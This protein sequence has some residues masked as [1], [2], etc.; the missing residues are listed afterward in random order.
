MRGLAKALAR[1]DRGSQL[2]LDAARKLDLAFDEFLPDVSSWSKAGEYW[3]AWAYA[4]MLNGISTSAVNIISS[5]GYI[6]AAPALN[7]MAPSE[8]TFAIR[9]AINAQ[10]GGKAKLDAFARSSPVAAAAVKYVA[11]FK[12]IKQARRRASDIFYEGHIDHKFLEQGKQALGRQ[13]NIL[14][15]RAATF[16]AAKGLLGKYSAL[17]KFSARNLAAQDVFI[18]TIAHEMQLADAV[19]RADVFMKRGDMA[20]LG[21]NKDQ[22]E[23]AGYNLPALRSFSYPQWVNFQMSM[24][25]PAY[26]GA[27]EI[28]IQDVQAHEQLTGGLTNAQ[29]KRYVETRTKEVI[30]FG[31]TNEVTGE[32]IAGL[33]LSEK[34]FED[35]EIIARSQIFTHQ[36][37]GI[38]SKWSGA[39]AKMTSNKG[40]GKLLWP[41]IPFT[42]II[43]NLSDTM[44]DFNPVT[45]IARAN[46]ISMSEL[47]AEFQR[48]NGMAGDAKKVRPVLSAKM[49]D[50]YA[51][52]KSFGDFVGMRVKRA[53]E[54]KDSKYYEQMARAWTGIQA[55]TALALTASSN[56]YEGFG[57]TGS[58][59]DKNPYM[60]MWNG[61]PVI[62]YKDI[63]ALGPAAAIV[64]KWHEYARENPDKKDAEFYED[65]GA[66][67]WYVLGS[68]ETL[69][70]KVSVAEGSIRVMDIF[71]DLL[72]FQ[73]G[74]QKNGEDTPDFGDLLKGLGEK[75]SRPYLSVLTKPLPQR[76]S[77]VEQVEQIFDPTVYSKSDILD[78]TTYAF[79]GALYKL[80]GIEKV[81]MVDIFGDP[82]IKLPGEDRMG[83]LEYFRDDV[84]HRPWVKFLNERSIVFAPLQNN[85]VAWA[86]KDAP[87]GVK[88]EN[89][90]TKQFAYYAKKSGENFKKLLNGYTD[91]DGEHVEGIMEVDRETQ[92]MRDNTI[93]MY[94][95]KPVTVT[96]KLVRKAMTDA[97][98]LARKQVKDKF[99]TSSSSP[100]IGADYEGTEF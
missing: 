34:E 40:A 49:G 99:E 82:V 36:R 66:R 98:S 30:R 58:Q 70:G 1:T 10:G 15:R 60:I 89:Y 43:G 6:L 39:L 76:A 7:I 14:E 59:D 18:R 25:N 42:T 64:A 56:P 61:K 88:Y 63:P 53:F 13:M 85:A 87:F 22:L 92:K 84:G 35:A 93:E 71:S 47:I 79:T 74:R 68:A 27:V 96:E 2:E 69:P 83:F 62:S 51:P 57:L 94:G 9:N 12:G 21:F 24:N 100:M 8:W 19:R 46:G 54:T 5:S 67:L 44:A 50:Q 37:G 45:G 16:K 77:I 38:H 28:A 26:K 78:A 65:A 52:A 4:N 32:K 48:S 86:D 17:L 11:G 33:R 95:Q 29:R 31:G 97:R 3:K 55:L 90:D 20:A 91:E 75:I 72:E 73:M 41:L 81:E 80:P 23:A